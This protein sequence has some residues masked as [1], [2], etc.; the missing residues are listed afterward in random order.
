[1]KRSFPALAAVSVAL[2][3]SACDGASNA[4]GPFDAG[5]DTGADD[6]AGL[7]GDAGADAVD[8]QGLSGETVLDLDE[9]KT[10]PGSYDWFDFKPNV[11]KLILAGA[12]ETEHVAILWYTITEGA[13]GLH[14]HAKTESVFVIDGTQTDAKGVYPTGTVYFN[15][16]GSG[17]EIMHSSGFFILAYAAPPDFASTS[18]IGEYTPVRIDTSAADLTTAYPF[19]ESSAGVR[20]FSPAL[21]STG[22]M[23]AAFIDITS[24]GDYAYRGN[25]LLV[26]KGSCDIEGVTLAKDKLVVGKTVTPRS[27]K[28]AASTGSACL[29]MGVSF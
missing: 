9:V 18:L 4:P 12:P 15:P 21:D 7:P 11:K 24:A 19:A 22:G 17:H 8:P 10:S 27:Y 5:T 13:V 25:Y 6:A 14:Y 1:M 16:P 2:L 23:T 20:V 26:L 28:V 29:A 3:L